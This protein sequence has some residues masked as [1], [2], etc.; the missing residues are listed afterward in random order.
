MILVIYI[1]ELYTS[2]LVSLSL[3]QQTYLQL[4]AILYFQY[5]TKLQKYKNYMKKK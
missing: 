5:H 3:L 2:A 4:C 1:E